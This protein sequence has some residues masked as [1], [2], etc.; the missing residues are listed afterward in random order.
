MIKSRANTL[1]ERDA[2]RKRIAF[3]SARKG[4][5]GYVGVRKAGTD[6]VR[7]VTL[8]SVKAKDRMVLQLNTLGCGSTAAKRNAMRVA[9]QANAGLGETTVSAVTGRTLGKT[10]IEHPKF[11]V[12]RLLK[13][14]VPGR[15]RI[16]FGEKEV[17][18]VNG[19]MKV[20]SKIR[21][22]SVEA[23]Q[24]LGLVS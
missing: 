9:K 19:V 24:A 16:S 13:T 10:Q 21:V 23:L 1:A 22:F 15:I 7:R 14:L 8:K 12:G 20:R 17:V 3:A 18:E 2:Q 11:G 5:K 6:E 4:L